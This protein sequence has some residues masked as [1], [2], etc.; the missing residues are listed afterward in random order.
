MRVEVLGRDCAS[1]LVLS[2]SQKT[3]LPI[4]WWDREILIGRSIVPNKERLA[5]HWK[6]L[7]EG[8]IPRGC[9]GKFMTRDRFMHI[10]RNLHF[11]SELDP[12]AAKDPAWKLRPVIDKIALPLALHHQRSWLLTR[13]CCHRALRSIVCMCT[14][15]TS[16]TGGA[17]SFSCCGFRQRRTAFGDF[18]V[19]C[20]KK[21]RAGSTS[22]TDQ[23][24]GPAA[25]ARNLQHA[26]GSMAPA[27]G[28]MLL[29]VMDRFY[30]P[31]PL[32]LQLLTMD[33]I[34]P[35]PSER[36]VKA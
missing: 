12:R 30:S 33:S 8:A 32:S 13:Q 36:I 11:S 24:S 18:E 27:S 19:Y 31:V 22:S 6:T 10:S 20:G 3:K 35:G 15:W 2:G 28:E 1:Y 4:N 26:L 7:E 21:E 14:S 5:N 29:I 9:F 17:H 25:V 16:P 34:P 23:K